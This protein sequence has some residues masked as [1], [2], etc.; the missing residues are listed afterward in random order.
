MP[1]AAAVIAAA[2][3]LAPFSL[4]SS[5]A[6]NLNREALYMTINHGAPRLSCLS[7]CPASLAS[8]Y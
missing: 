8:E 7:A 2:R 1:T 3:C 6:S 4:T 5:S